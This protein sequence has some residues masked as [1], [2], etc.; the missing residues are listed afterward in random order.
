MVTQLFGITTR[1]YKYDRT[2]GRDENFGSGFRDPLDVAAAPDGRLYVVNRL[3]EFHPENVHVTML[4]IDEEYLGQFGSIGDGEGQFKWSVGIALD[5]KRNVYVTDEWL[6]RIAIFDKDGDF[7][8]NWDL[9]GSG[10]GQLNKPA[11]I[12]IDKNDNIYVVDSGNH[13]IQVFDNNGRFLRKWGELGTDPG[14]FN[15]PWGIGLDGRGDVY[16]ADWRN[17]RMQKF[18]AEGEFLMTFGSSG[19]AAGEFNRPV[20]V[21]V[22]SDGD[23]YVSDSSNDRVQAFTP[24]GRYITNFE[25]DAVMSKWGEQILS[26]NAHMLKAIDLVQDMTPWQRFWRPKGLVVDSE[27]RIIIVDGYRARLQIYKKAKQDSS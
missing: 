8:A 2:I 23:I 4:N 27:D 24:D 22:D 13:R 9:G 15:L 12:K 17:D 21:A 1:S 10:D 6:N 5:S 25:G 16:V 19:S 20:G 11:G 3:V 7:I 18:S 26:A 14:Q